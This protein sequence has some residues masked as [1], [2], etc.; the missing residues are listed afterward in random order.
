MRSV[1]RIFRAR[2]AITPFFDV[3]IAKCPFEHLLVDQ[4]DDLLARVAIQLSIDSFH[5]GLNGSRG[6][7]QGVRYFLYAMTEGKLV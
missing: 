2:R 6:N 1:F 7:K 3:S 4:I 5:V